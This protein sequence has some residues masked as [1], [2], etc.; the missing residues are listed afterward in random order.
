MEWIRFWSSRKVNEC[1]YPQLKGMGRKF[2]WK[3]QYGW[4]TGS[5]QTSLT[6]GMRRSRETLSS[7]WFKIRH[8]LFK[9][10]YLGLTII[11]EAPLFQFPFDSDVKL[12]VGPSVLHLLT[13]WQLVELN[14]RSFINHIRI[15]IERWPTKM[16]EHECEFDSALPCSHNIDW[17][18]GLLTKELVSIS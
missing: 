1:M 5:E 10:Y 11:W 12:W 3:E 4:V 9:T 15:R 6:E 2:S 13:V 18:Q 17:N 14:L 7:I 16:K 8:I